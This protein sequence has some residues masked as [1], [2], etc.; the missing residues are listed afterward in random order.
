M[1]SRRAVTCLVAGVGT[2]AFV[3]AAGYV[4][5]LTLGLAP[6]PVPAPISQ[7]RF[8][9]LPARWDTGWYVGIASGGYF[10]PATPPSSERLKF[11]PAYSLLLRAVA[12]TFNPGRSPVVWV[13][14]GVVLSTALFCLAL[15]A[16]SALAAALCGDEAASRTVWA[17][18]TYPFA[19]F[20]G[21]PYSESLFLLATTSATVALLHRRCWQLAFW[22]TLSGMTRPSGFLLAALLFLLGLNSR[23]VDRRLLLASLAPLAGTAVFTIYLGAVTGHS[24]AWAVGQP[25]WRS[26]VNPFAGVATVYDAV[27]VAAALFASVMTAFTFRR[28][29]GPYASFMALSLAMALFGIG[30]NCMGRYT[31][32]LFPMFVLV[33]CTLR[34]GVFLSYAVVCFALE[35]AAAAAFFT[36]RPLY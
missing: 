7:N 26:V 11:F 5:V 24:L 14:T 6:R 34:R 32:T 8:A 9:D 30:F 13:W 27:N 28:L 16:V 12:G 33:G 1:L 29:G 19:I 20:Y 3:L 25:G 31:S 4:A 10:R 36:W 18:A 23:V 21:L 35:C 17:V 2:R 15:L 22:G